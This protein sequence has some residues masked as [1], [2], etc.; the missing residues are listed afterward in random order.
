[1]GEFN[2][3]PINVPLKP[4][5]A[6]LMMRVFELDVFSCPRCGGSMRILCLSGICQV[7]LQI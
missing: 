1:M 3:S 6:Q 7:Q 5:L 2:D 4:F